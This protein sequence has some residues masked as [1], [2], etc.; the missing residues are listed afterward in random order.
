MEQYI[1][2]IHSGPVNGTVVVPGSKSMTNRAL[3]LAAL[4]DEKS[5]LQG[6]LFSDDSRHFL[7]SLCELGFELEINE[8]EKTVVLQGCGGRIPRKTATIDVGSAGTA[9]RFLTTMLAL[10][11]GTYRILCSEQ[12][13]ARPMEELFEILTGL[14]A[15]FTYL[16]AEGHLPVE[17]TGRAFEKAEANKNTVVTIHLDISRSTQYLSALLMMAP[18]MKEDVEIH[19]TS[20]KK[21]GSYIEITR[22]MLE[23]FGVDTAFDG[24]TYYIKGNQEIRIGEYYIEPDVSAACYFYG[25]AAMTGGRIVV[26]NVF[27]TSMQGDMKFVRL[28]EQLGCVLEETPEGIAVTGPKDGVYPGIDVD[29]NDF[30]DQ[31]LTLAALAA[32]ATSE[33]RIR[34][35][36]HIRG[37]ECNRMEAIVREL[38]KC[39]IMAREEG[40]DIVIPAGTPHGAIIETYDDHRVAMAFTLL[41]LKVEDIVIDNPMCCRKTFEDFYSVLEMLLN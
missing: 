33:T 19:I 39:G 21:N 3:L 2:K 15:K 23:S 4:S 27:F 38:N 7:D 10:S 40:D 5:L 1:G 41:S 8:E 14:G 34:N 11:D 24:E 36:G 6:V 28:L 31:A 16:E 9:A 26:K 20:Q 22:R 30:S 12:M 29:M 25:I 17:V 37:Q 32:F 35:V 18:S 13:K